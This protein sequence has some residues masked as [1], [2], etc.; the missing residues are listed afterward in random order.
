MV[1]QSEWA[2]VTEALAHEVRGT[3]VRVLATSPGVVRTEFSSV[4]GWAQDAALPLLTPEVVADVSL[5]AV[6][7]GRVVRVIGAVWRLLALL[8][9]ITPRPIMRWIMGRILGR[10]LSSGLTTQARAVAAPSR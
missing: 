6:A 9:A 1:T 3:G 4:A 2:V 10:S 7:R 5:R 8:A